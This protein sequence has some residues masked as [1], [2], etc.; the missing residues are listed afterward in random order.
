RHVALERP[1][2]RLERAS[3]PGGLARELV[4][5]RF[6]RL[7]ELGEDRERREHGLQDGH[8]R[9]ELPAQRA[10]GLELLAQRA[11]IVRALVD[12]VPVGRRVHGPVGHL[13]LLVGHAR[14]AVADAPG[15]HVV[16]LPRI[17]LHPVPA[18][19]APALERAA[20]AAAW[21]LA[22]FVT[23]SCSRHGAERTA[24][25]AH[26]IDSTSL[27]AIASDRPERLVVPLAGRRAGTLT[28]ERVSVTRAAIEHATVSP[29]PL[30]ASQITPPERT[31]LEP[32]PPQADPD[33]P[34]VAPAPAA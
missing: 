22:A 17:E 9:G 23:V 8:V 29:V 5:E 19:A 25:H 27:G 18:E 31:A 11:L 28:L 7:G 14:V 33:E 20:R 2:D 1:R 12:P 15:L 30:P 21:A 24:A 4:T 13:G 6:G 32:P 10:Y 3:D 34:P 26:A 16:V